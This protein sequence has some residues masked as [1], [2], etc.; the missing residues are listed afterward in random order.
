MGE[1]CLLKDLNVFRG[2]CKLC[3]VREAEKDKNENVSNVEGLANQG[4][5]VLDLAILQV[6]ER[7]LQPQ[8]QGDG[9]R[10]DQVVGHDEVNRTKRKVST[11]LINLYMFILEST[12][13]S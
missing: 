4:R 5:V 3:D 12:R 7:D 2:G 11:K 10:L 1:I 8:P 9:G 6:G 13:C